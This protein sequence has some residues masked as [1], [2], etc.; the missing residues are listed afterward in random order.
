LLDTLDHIPVAK[1]LPTELAVGQAQRIGLVRALS[2]EPQLL[3]L[4]ESFSRLDR[5]MADV[6]REMFTRLHRDRGLTSV[7]VTHDWGQALT[8]ADSVIVLGRN[9]RIIQH[10]TPTEAYERPLTLEA[11]A[12]T[13]P[14]N[15]LSG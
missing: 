14:I 2:S 10:S 12:L 7:L 11:A 5:P 15:V 4:D 3:L 6:A 13:G 1:R 9:G 8:I